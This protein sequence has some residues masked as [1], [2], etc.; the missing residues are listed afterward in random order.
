MHKTACSP[1]FRTL[2]DVF[3]HEVA[4]SL[5]R[6]SLKNILDHNCRKWAE[7]TL[8]QAL[9]MEKGPSGETIQSTRI[10]GRGT[11]K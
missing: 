11:N 10:L 5:S 4:S 9:V 6:E 8:N 2:E 7:V 1:K 3:V